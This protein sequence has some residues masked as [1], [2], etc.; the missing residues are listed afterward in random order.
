M[1]LISNLFKASK[2]FTIIHPDFN[3]KELVNSSFDPNSQLLTVQ[4]TCEKI[5]AEYL[6][7][8]PLEVYQSDPAKGKLKQKSHDLYRLLHNKFNHFQTSTLAI[9]QLERWRN[10]YG[11]SFA[12]IWRNGA[13]K[14]VSL[15][16]IHPNQIKGYKIV[17]N[18]LFWYREWEENGKE[19]KETLNNDQVLHFRFIS[20][21][22]IV[23]LNP[24]QVLIKELD[25]IHQGRTTLN[26]AYK[27][28][29]NIDKYFEST[30]SN[31][32]SKNAKE[33][34]EELRKEYSGSLNSK[35][36]PVLPA[37][38]K[39]ASIQ[40]A[41]IQD[42]QILESMGVSKADVYGLYNLPVP[43]KKS[44]N[45]LE[46]ETLNLKTNTLQPIA[47]MYRQELEAKMLSDEDIEQGM[48]IE[49]NLDAVVEVDMK[50][51]SEYLRTLQ[52]G[53]VISA[54][55]I[56]KIAGFET[57]EGG[58]LHF[59]QSQNIPVEEYEK[60]AKATKAGPINQQTNN[61]DNNQDN[62]QDS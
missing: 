34:V 11:N 16:L 32:S 23:G 40:G 18:K 33:S 1:G 3:F 48:S 13:G 6:A 45:S 29:L 30:I 54:N 39:L 51:R 7:K 61:Q 50:T 62:D 17:N 12:K 24:S 55:D 47:R 14:V 19:K 38:F 58:D 35:K 10:H 60:Y 41:S 15:E 36:T 26:N 9:Q 28:N 5:L 56:A 46:Q 27:N 2:H 49:F 21:D 22:G 25:N 57:Y 52:Q 43:E 31:F 42:A 20:E 44:Y 4:L 59:I 8:L 53:A 37:G